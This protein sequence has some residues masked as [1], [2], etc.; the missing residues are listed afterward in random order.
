LNPPHLVVAADRVF[1][2]NQPGRMLRLKPTPRG[3]E[4]FV[5]DATFSR[6]IPNT[7]D[8]TRMWLDPHGRI[9]MT[10]NGRSLAVLFPEG[11]ISGEMRNMLPTEVLDEMM[12]SDEADQ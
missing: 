2:F 9:C 4:P 6:G 11:Y 1:L 10:W 7:E 3:P 12:R 8:L 5:L